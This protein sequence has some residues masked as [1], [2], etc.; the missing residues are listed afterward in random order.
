MFRRERR[1]KAEYLLE[2]SK[3]DIKSGIDLSKEELRLINLKD[4]F[5][6]YK[7]SD[8][9]LSS[10]KNRGYEIY[11]YLDED[12]KIIISQE[13]KLNINARYCFSSYYTLKEN[14]VLENF[15]NNKIPLSNVLLHIERDIKEQFWEIEK[16][17]TD[18]LKTRP[19]CDWWEVFNEHPFLILIVN[20]KDFYETLGEQAFFKSVRYF[21]RNDIEIFDYL[22][23]QLDLN[24]KNRDIVYFLDN[25]TNMKDEY[26]KLTYETYLKRIDYDEV[27]YDEAL[28][29]VM[30]AIYNDLITEKTLFSAVYSSEKII[31]RLLRMY[32]NELF[33]FIMK[34]KLPNSIL[35][36]IFRNIKDGEP[37]QYDTKIEDLIDTNY[38]KKILYNIE[39][40]EY[41]FKLNADEC[42]MKITKLL[43]KGIKIKFQHYSSGGDYYTMHTNEIEYALTENVTILAKIFDVSINGLLDRIK[44]QIL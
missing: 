33:N 14:S 39:I 6:C 18:F 22:Y 35:E 31:N 10:L 40:S 16:D 12:F 41:Y 5:D 15:L 30:Y 32:Q 37:L 17:I 26:A 21:S 34:Q 42:L 29:L 36:K 8:L 27:V 1:K 28:Y 4:K 13:K 9:L 3:I 23:S 20:I 19:T 38:N 25:K 24:P 43:L 2:F 44:F 11:V 7:D